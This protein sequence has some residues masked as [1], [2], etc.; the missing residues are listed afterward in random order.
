[1]QANDWEGLYACFHLGQLTSKISADYEH[2][3][4]GPCKNLNFGSEFPGTDFEGNQ[5]Y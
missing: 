4:G 1:M 2:T 3:R 5:A